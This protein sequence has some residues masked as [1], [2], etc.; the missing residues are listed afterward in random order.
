MIPYDKTY[1]LK[2][3]YLISIQKISYQVMFFHQ[4]KKINL[5]EKNRS[6]V[7]SGNYLNT[8]ALNSYFDSTTKKISGT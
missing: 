1:E 6:P 7:S 5:V 3:T 2:L 8:E 4:H